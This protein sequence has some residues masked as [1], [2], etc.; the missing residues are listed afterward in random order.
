MFL[1]S[2]RLLHSQKFQCRGVD[3]DYVYKA[4]L[5]HSEA[6]QHLMTPIKGNTCREQKKNEDKKGEFVRIM[7]IIL[8][9]YNL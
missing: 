7:T 6:N 3:A 9:T 8:L 1:S 4:K 5:M 2:K